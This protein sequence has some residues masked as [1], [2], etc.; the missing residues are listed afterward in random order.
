VQVRDGLGVLAGQVGEQATDVVV[1]VGALLAAGQ[2]ADEGLEES[3]QAR[4]Y[5]PLEWFDI[6][7]STKEVAL[8]L[9]GGA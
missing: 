8:F 1:G 7:L 2:Q 9:S 4:P 5:A 6:C 3:L